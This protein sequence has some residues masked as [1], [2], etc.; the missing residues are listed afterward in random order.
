MSGANLTNAKLIESDL[1]FA[2]Q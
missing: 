2:Q 1:A